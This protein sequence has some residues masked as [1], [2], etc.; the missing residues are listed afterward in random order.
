M[1]FSFRTYLGIAM[2]FVVA[3]FFANAA[4][5]RIDMGRHNQAIAFSMNN[6]P[7]LTGPDKSCLISG[8]VIEEFSGGGN[9][10]TDVYIWKIISP[11]NQVLFEDEGR[12]SYQNIRY[13]FSLQ[14]THTIELEVE[15]GGKPIYSDSKKVQLL[16]GPSISTLR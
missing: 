5:T 14:G 8:G 2:F 6:D 16:Q 13:T 10:E 11:S 15:R 3:I 4:L 7:L 12:A 9:P 1:Y